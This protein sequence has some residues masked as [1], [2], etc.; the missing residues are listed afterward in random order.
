MGWTLRRSG[1]RPRWGVCFPN[2]RWD[3][4]NP[5]VARL[6]ENR[7]ERASFSCDGG[8]S[9]PNS[10]PRAARSSRARL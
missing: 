9:H 5:G 6:R 2:G 10:R 3:V 1:E 7:N 8:A 4:K